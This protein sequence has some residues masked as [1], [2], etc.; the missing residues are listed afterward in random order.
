[1]FA[2]VQKLLA[3]RGTFLRFCAAG[4]IGF[5][6]DAGIVQALVSLFGLPPVPIR[7][8]SFLVAVT[9]TWQ[10]N[11]K[12]TFPDTRPE[13]AHRQWGLY[14]TVNAV[15]A[16]AN[17]GIYMLLVINFAAMSRFPFFAVLAASAI[18]LAINYTASKRLVF[19]PARDAGAP[20]RRWRKIVA[21][22]VVLSSVV[23]LIQG[24]KFKNWTPVYD[25]TEYLG[26]GYSLLHDRT[27]GLPTPQGKPQLSF[28]R[29]P[30]YPLVIAAMMALD[31]RLRAVLP[32]CWR[33]AA[34]RCDPKSYRSLQ[35]LNLA[36]VAT[37]ALL[38]G[39]TVLRLGGNRAAALVGAGA[40]VFNIQAQSLR[41][42]IM[43]DYLAMTLLALAV[44]FGVSMLT[45]PT[46]RKLAACGFSLAALVLTKA[47][48]FYFVV[49]IVAAA[50]IAA[51]IRRGHRLGP[52]VAVLAV[53]ALLPVFAWMGFQK[54]SGGPFALVDDHRMGIALSGREHFNDMNRT[55]WATAFLWWTR[56]FGDNVARR[57]LPPESY[58]RIDD[59]NGDSFFQA[60]EDRFRR[61]RE[62]L[63]RS[64]G[65]SWAE[66]NAI[67]I[68]DMAGRILDRPLK[69]L[70]VSL[71]LAYR[72]AWIDEFAWAS[73]PAL[74]VVLIAAFRR[75]YWHWMLAAAPGVYSL[76][77]YP[78]S[79]INIPRYQLTAMPTLA[80]ALALAFLLWRKR[81]DLRAPRPPC[82]PGKSPP[83][84]Q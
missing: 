31:P 14:L 21:V 68:R 43:S 32:D 73:V 72:G 18:V 13:R 66:A 47:I 61:M 81:R 3:S 75:R 4:S 5:I 28:A 59:G 83:Y 42:Y 50:G 2:A 19:A 30:G 69:H 12:L 35:W 84:S 41:S 8:I 33:E 76:V 24:A 15:G 7:L 6:V 74:F 60:G 82:G 11:R 38:V 10:I 22:F 44:W 46:R 27:Y 52:A 78:L 77:I 54:A 45:S 63:M 34:L 16:L 17:L 25:E 48:Y 65:L 37:T 20:D 62:E 56:A 80:L 51:L 9:V 57:K 71:P 29:E 36:M 49:I 64:G 79:S 53:A 67:L 40:I 1:M 58:R 70:A 23:L 39:L 55:E 26:Y